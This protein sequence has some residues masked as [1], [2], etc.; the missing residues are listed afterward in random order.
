[1]KN[2]IIIIISLFIGA[3][4]MLTFLHYV[5]YEGP[6]ELT[7]E[8]W[9]E[10]VKSGK[11]VVILVT[12]ENCRACRVYEPIF[13]HVAKEMKNEATFYKLSYWGE[14]H[15]VALYLKVDK[16]PTTIIF[17]GKIIKKFVGIRQKEILKAVVKRYAK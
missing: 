12:S 9:G 8:K 17:R 7:L 16:V 11:P 4:L 6:P 3:M 15:D 1:M 14:A 10:I 2:L 5:K 13:F